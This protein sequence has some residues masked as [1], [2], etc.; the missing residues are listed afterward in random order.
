M[1]MVDVITYM[2]KQLKGIERKGF[3]SLSTVDPFLNS[4]KEEDKNTYFKVIN[5]KVLTM[6]KPLFLVKKMCGLSKWKM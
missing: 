3:K 5:W 1:D 4:M 6:L 2:K